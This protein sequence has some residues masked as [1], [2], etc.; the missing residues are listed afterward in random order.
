MNV[1]ELYFG[2]QSLIL[3]NGK[4][5]FAVHN[6]MLQSKSN[7][8]SVLCTLGGGVYGYI[9]IIMFP[10]TYVTLTPCTPFIVPAPLGPLN[11]VNN[12][13][14]YQIVHTTSLH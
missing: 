5:M 14:P 3:I 8:L 12:A 6:M 1:R 9:C 13:T 7:A 11:V 10:V 2:H 4:P